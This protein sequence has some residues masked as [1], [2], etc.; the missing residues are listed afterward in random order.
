LAALIH[1][2]P[3]KTFIL[4]GDGGYATADLAD[5][6]SRHGHPLVSRCRPDLA[7]FAPPP[8]RTQGQMGRPRL[9]GRRLDSPQQ[10]AERKTAPWKEATVP[11]YGG[12]TRKVRLLTGT[13]LWYNRGRRLVMIRW[14]YVVDREGTH[15]DDCLFSTDSTLSPEEIVG[16]F[17]R[18]WSIE[19]TC[20]E[21]R[22]HLGFET[23]RQWTPK[24]VLRTGPCLLGLFTVVSLIFA[25]H[26]RD[27]RVLPAAT[28]WYA[29]KDITFS[30]ALALVRRLLW[31]KTVFGTSSYAHEYTKV[32]ARFRTLV[33]HH[34]CRT[35]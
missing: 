29:K 13:G 27:H 4:L 33:L 1:A 9:K 22:A 14:V 10:A 3:Q 18:R 15:R 34:L 2:F 23:T 20:E 8:T 21:V 19:V 26:A 25:A 17:T 24:S 32:P 11:W 5:F 30:D 12:G 28:A 6:C 16:L 7:L 35:A 31:T